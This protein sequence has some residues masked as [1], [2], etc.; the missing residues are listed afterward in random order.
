M[1]STS[2]TSLNGAGNGRAT[3]AALNRNLPLFDWYIMPEAYSAPLVLDAIKEFSVPEGGTV[4]DPFCGTGTTLV[5]ARLAGRNAVGIEVNPFLC[6]ASRVKTRERFNLPLLRVEADRLL[7]AARLVLRSVDEGK[8]PHLADK[9]P[10]MPRLERWI[11]RRVALKVLALRDLIEEYFSPQ[12][13]EIGLLALAAILRGASNMKLSP[14]A[15]GSREVKNDAPVMSLF[16]MRLGKMLD[17]VQWL[18]TQENLGRAQV[19]EGDVRKA[20]EVE[21]KLLPAQL[22]IT[23]PPYL[24]NL[25]YTMQTRMELFFLGFVQSM[26]ELKHLRKRMMICDAKATYKDIEDWRRVEEV[27]SV[28]DVARALD[29]ELGDRNWGWNYGL[30]TRQYFGGLLRSLEA[31]K[32]LLAPGAPFVVILGESAHAGILVPVPDITAE[33]GRLAGY[34]ATEVRV[35]RTRRS[36]SHKFGL[37]ESAVVLRRNE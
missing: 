30:M 27:K 28:A 24:N 11:A 8:M 34:E 21:H 9:F 18:Q 26:E 15:F 4:L 32:P 31:V 16:E 35:L 25:D 12:N 29:E 19:I 33:L 10:D 2:A 13:R 20:R 36:S 22:A 23:S 6:M 5:A 3:T 7:G 1:L 37:K 14:H 17:D